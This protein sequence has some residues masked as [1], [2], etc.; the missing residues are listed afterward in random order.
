MHDLLRRE[1]L[2]FDPEIPIERAWTPPASWY[3]DAEIHHLEQ[4]AVFAQSWLA[5]ARL[6]QLARPGQF[7]SGCVAGMPWVVVRGA[8]GELR[9]F[10]NV[11]RHKG[12]EV[13]RGSGQADELVC[14]YHAWSYTLDGRLKKAPRIG[15]IQEFDRETM[16]LP[17]LNVATFGA[18]IFVNADPAAPPLHLDELGRRL[19]ERNLGSYRYLESTEW[20][21]AANWKAVVD[22]YLDGGYHIPH[23]HPTLDAQLDMDSYRTELAGISCIQTSG[24]AAAPDQRIAFDAGKRIGPGAI[25]AWIHPN[26]MINVYGPCIDTNT[27]LPLGPDRCRVVYDFFVQEGAEPFARDSIAQSAVTQRED[28]EI[29]ESIQVGMTSP[30]FD[31][32]RYAPTV[33]IGEHHFHRLLAQQLQRALSDP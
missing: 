11:C 21:I 28:I 2:R 23:M 30:S 16:S 4:R 7:V 6:E 14:G 24:A 10:H 32:G 15:G 19:A 29:C 3:T 12:R 8:D 5:V 33:E 20:I 27:V 31:R 13:V 26:F 9:A 25:Y 17:S 1:V 22:N 18:W